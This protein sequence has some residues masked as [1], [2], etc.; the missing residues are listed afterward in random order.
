[1][2]GPWYRTIKRDAPILALIDQGDLA[3]KEVARQLQISVH[4][5]YKALNRRQRWR[6]LYIMFHK[7][8]VGET[9]RIPSVENP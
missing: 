4:V 8:Q 7:E 3:P 2:S 5:V 1:M 6:F 9:G